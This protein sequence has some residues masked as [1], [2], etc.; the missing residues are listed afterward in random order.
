VN[1]RKSLVEDTTYE[2]WTRTLAINLTGTFLMCR[3]VIPIMKRQ[4]WGRIVNMSSR[5][6]RTRSIL[7]SAH[8]A[9][10]KAGMLGFARIMADE[11]GPFGITV[12]SLTP[13][14]IST[15]MAATVADPGAIDRAFIAETPLGRVGV[16]A[17]VSAAV[18]YLVSDEAGFI[19]GAILDITGGQFMP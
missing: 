6:G 18:A 2:D 5:A 1:G 4:R 17:D 3:A 16:P 13:T 10:S 19:T 8:Y 15:P 7:A 9:A 11:V 12:N 14:R